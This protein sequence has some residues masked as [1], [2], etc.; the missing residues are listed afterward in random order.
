MTM[1]VGDG[2]AAEQRRLAAAS[3][4]A[5]VLARHV[6]DLVQLRRDQ[7]PE[8]VQRLSI[9]AGW[10]I[11]QI[12]GAD[13]AP[14][15]IA[16]YGPHPDGR[17]DGCETIS[18][19]RFTGI[20]PDGVVRDNADCTL[21]DLDAED[22]TTST[23]VASMIPGVTAVRCNGYFTAAG[24]R[25]WAQY[26][27][28]VVGSAVLGEGRLIQHSLFIESSCRARLTDGIAQLSNAVQRAFIDSINGR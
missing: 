19:F 18:V 15:R 14:S 8:W 11:A 6:D 22:I 5:A 26:S 21:R 2:L 28:Y 10:R 25:V 16:V 1:P 24:Q 9:P 20:S 27:I 7:L 3:S 12:E 4:I 17:W 13:V 23:P